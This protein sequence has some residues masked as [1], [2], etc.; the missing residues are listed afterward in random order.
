MRDSLTLRVAHC[1]LRLVIDI[2]F[3]GWTMK[4]IA[5]PEVAV[6]VDDYQ[7]HVSRRK[8][9]VA[10]VKEEMAALNRERD[11]II[12]RLSAASKGKP[13]AVP[14]GDG[15]KSVEFKKKEGALDAEK[16]AETLRS[17]RRKPSRKAGE[18]V[19]IVREMTPDEVEL[20]PK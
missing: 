2:H 6:A 18:Q 14:D 1:I 12:A 19:P 5:R 4:I 11:T 3:L 9:Y 8:S 16:M 17:I 20:L 15:F 13:F 7:A 10:S